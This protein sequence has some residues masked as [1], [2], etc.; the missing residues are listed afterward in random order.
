MESGINEEDRGEQWREQGVKSA[1]AGTR[2][3][4]FTNR[5]QK[6]KIPMSGFVNAMRH[7][8]TF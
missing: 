3:T 8:N 6:R 4:L 5:L 1:S 7:G 2:N